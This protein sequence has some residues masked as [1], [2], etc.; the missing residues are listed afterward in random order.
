MKI[1]KSVWAVLALL[2]FTACSEDDYKLY[3]ITQKDNVFF[4]YKNE[5][6]VNDSV[7]SYN[8]GYDFANEHIVEIPVSLMGMPSDKD[9][10]I[11]LK[12]VA[13]E[14]EMVEGTHYVIDRALLRAN[15]VE[16]TVRV[17]LL[18]PDDP[19]FQE[20][21]LALRLEIVTSDDLAPTGQKTFTVKGSDI[22]P[23]VRPS[24]WSTWSPMPVYSFENAQLFF[25]YFYELAPKANKD[26]FEEM[27]ARYGDYFVNGKSLQGPLAMYEA[28]LAQYVLIPMY[29]ETKDDIEWQA[30]PVVN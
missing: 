11:A 10:T 26:V 18:R 15:R 30:I 3:D 7:I 16:D 6:N 23:T 19:T 25:K 8:F 20:R 2:A 28:F 5:K 22:R 24:W 21:A 13:D 4:D 12:V 14:T 29:N 17:K 9:R 27:I 1:W